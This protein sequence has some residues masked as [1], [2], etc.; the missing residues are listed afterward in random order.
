MIFS[1]VTFLFLFLPL[2]LTLVWLAGQRYRNHVLLAGSL[3]FYAWGEG[4][5]CLL[6]I[7]SVLMNYLLGRTVEQTSGGSR[8]GVLALGIVLNLLP[9]FLLKYAGFAAA[10]AGS[11]IGFAPPAWITAEALHLPAG[12][13]FFTFQAISYLIDVYRKIA[14]A[15]RRLVNCGLYISMFPQLIAGPIVRYHEI[16]SQLVR[17]AVD[18]QGFARGAE[19]FVFGLGKK[20]LLADPLGMKADQIFLLPMA[21]LSGP[22]AWLGALCFSLQIYYD[23]SGYSDMAIGLGR[24]FG[25]QFPENF[26]YPYVSRTIR[27]FWRRWHISL[28]SWLRDY[29]YIPLGGNRKGPARTYVNLLVVFLLCGLWHGANWT[30][31]AWGVWHGLFLV[32]ERLVPYQIR[33]FPSQAAGWFYTTLVVMIGWVV[34]RS[35]SLAY[36]FDYLGIMFGAGAGGGSLFAA[37]LFGDAKLMTELAAGIILSAPVYRAVR[38]RRQPGMLEA[39]PGVNAAVAVLARSTA[40]LALFGTISYFALI[41]IASRAYNPFLYFQF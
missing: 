37:R 27:E 3:L 18:R 24:M 13:S 16:A 22:E 26:N 6:L 19:R 23:F 5:F 17:R 28:S 2:V 30:F 34:F 35:P 14:P 36:A 25:F 10:T 29:L 40:R 12:I 1:S 39:K 38:Q 8:K 33:S 32:L 15:E 11:V 4:G 21:E 31:V 41:T 7:G 20:V 9:L